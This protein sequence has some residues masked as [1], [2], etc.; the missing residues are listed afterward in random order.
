[1]E[2]D[3]GSITVKE[4]WGSALD[5]APYTQVEI[6]IPFVGFRN[7][8]IEDIQGL[9][10]SMKY[11]VDVLTGDCVAYLKCGQSVLYSWT[12]N[13]LAH[14]PCTANS[15]DLLAKNISAVGAVG[16]GLA[17]GNPA[18]TAAGAMAGAVNTATAKNHVQ[19]SGDVA[20]S[21]GLMSEFTPYLVFHRPKQSLAK[22][23][24]QFKGYPA[25]ITYKLS[26]LQ[27]Y[28]EVEHVH[29]TG[30]KATDTELQEIEDLLK[31]GVII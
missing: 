4:F 11:H 19:R 5:Y 12:G 3:A 31:S 9:T 16:L 23:Y 29:L 2:I 6:F 22:N 13:C 26:T 10:L 24:N 21:P 18:S 27:G 8:Q 28:T 1:M 7:L 30:I 25:N 20:G 15:S 14:I 17:T